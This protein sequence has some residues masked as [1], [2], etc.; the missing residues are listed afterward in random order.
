[1]RKRSSRILSSD[2][3]C[4]SSVSFLIDGEYSRFTCK[5]ITEHIPLLFRV[6]VTYGHPSMIDVNDCD[7]RL[8]SSGDA[9]DLYLDYLARLSL[10]LGRVMKNIYTCVR[11]PLCPIYAD[12]RHRVRQSGRPERND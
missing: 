10:I 1:M 9:T 11:S 6:G 12:R 8:P 4:G 5:H 2:D 3:V 7:A